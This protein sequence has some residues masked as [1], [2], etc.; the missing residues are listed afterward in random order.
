MRQDIGSANI[1]RVKEETV[2]QNTVIGLDLAKDSF[3]VVEL[4]PGGQETFKKTFRRG[5]LKQF[6]LRRQPATV[7]LEACGSAHY[8]GRWLKRQGHTPVL[9]PPQHVKGYLRG[10]KN[11][12]NDARAIAEACRHGAIRPVPVKTVA[13][14]DEQAFHALR[15]G[16]KAESTRLINQ[17]RGLLSEYGLT[18]PK[19]VG[20]FCKRVPELLEDAEN[21]LSDQ[22]R[23]L[24]GR[25]WERLKALREE[26]AWYDERL[27]RQAKEDDTCRR[28]TAVPGI[29]P[30]VASALKNWL[31]DGSQFQRG[32]EAS[33]ALGLVPKQYSTGGKSSLYGIT[34]R[35][36]AYLRS[37]VVH[38]AR[39]VVRTA[40][41]K[42]EALSQ[43]ALALQARRGHNRA[44][45]AVA[46]KLIRMAWVIVA[47]QEHYR[48]LE[49]RSWVQA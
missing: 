32:R 17:M 8:W 18:I 29:G 7:A 24:L 35:G 5:G 14:Q 38:G 6:L 3:A 28:L 27:Q 49:S 33:A 48:P 46:N 36:D 1:Q 20:G 23:L 44:V 2:K 45:I 25:Q 43:W 13:Q 4:G 11:D 19:S 34:K 30:V 42:Q 9:L 41:K 39:A 37:L 15:R 10:Q 21:G 16:L 31:G 26:Q 40:P 47:R 12:Y 22:F